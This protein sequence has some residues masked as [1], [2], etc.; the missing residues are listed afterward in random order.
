[1]KLVHAAFDNIMK[2]MHQDELYAVTQ[3]NEVD[4]V[5]CQ[6]KTVIQIMVEC[7]MEQKK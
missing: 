5:G 7:E 1:M 4:G 3:H 6:K 2:Q